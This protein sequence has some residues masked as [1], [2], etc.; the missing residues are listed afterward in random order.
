MSDC[1][2]QSFN[3]D[4]PI[5]YTNSNINIDQLTNDVDTVSCALNS[6]LTSITEQ[7]SN[8]LEESITIDIDEFIAC[9]TKFWNNPTYVGLNEITI[10]KLQQSLSG[11]GLT[12]NQINTIINRAKNIKKIQSWIFNNKNTGAWRTNL[13][14]ARNRVFHFNI[15]CT[16]GVQKYSLTT[17]GQPTNKDCSKLCTIPV[18]LEIQANSSSVLDTIKLSSLPELLCNNGPL[19]CNFSFSNTNFK[20]FYDNA[21]I[22][23]NPDDAIFTW[24]GES[25]N[26]IDEN[27]PLTHSVVLI[28]YECFPDNDNPTHYIF[29]FKDS[30]NYGNAQGGFRPGVFSIKIPTQN[31]NQLASTTTPWN[32]GDTYGLGGQFRIYGV[33]V[34]LVGS[35]EK[36]KKDLIDSKCCS[37]WYCIEEFDL[38]NNA[39]SACKEK[40]KFDPSIS[41]L[42]GYDT[43]E[44]CEANC[45]EASVQVTFNLTPINSQ[46][47]L[48]DL[49]YYLSQIN[50][51]YSIPVTVVDDIISGTLYIQNTVNNQIYGT[52]VSYYGSSIGYTIG[53]VLA[54]QNF[55]NGTQTVFSSSFTGLEPNPTNISLSTSINFGGW[56]YGS[57]AT[58]NT[59][60]YVTGSVNT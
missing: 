60:Y 6:L 43:Q 16:E 2:D 37:K 20:T 5:D 54:G 11:L 4:D 58:G 36:I 31:V 28:G 46:P 13:E 56:L 32:I 38:D 50:N 22:S 25:L 17:L 35:K 12:Q 45:G 33:I 47:N 27:S 30:Y 42:I 1:N 52:T 44:E 39:I 49:D 29:K 7:I 8:L 53:I 57:I 19:V 14:R 3:C 34:K 10:S 21:K 24:S 41:E 18:K 40:S 23:S 59:T 51:S 9:N 55:V 26:I 15:L 48:S